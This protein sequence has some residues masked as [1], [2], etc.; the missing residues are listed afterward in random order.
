MMVVGLTGG[1][2]SGKSTV[3]KAFES[4]GVPVFYADAVAK[5]QYRD[6]HL[7]QLLEDH[8]KMSLTD[9]HGALDKKALAQRIFSD[10][11]AREW[12]NGLIH[13][14]VKHAFKAWQDSLNQPAYVLR[15]AA[16][17]IESGAYRDCRAILVVTAPENQRIQRVMKRDGLSEQEVLKR[18]QSQW[19]DEQRLRFATHTLSNPNGEDIAP[20]VLALHRQ[21]LELAQNP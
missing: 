7:I 15:E 5:D 17:L 10:S 20:K 1:I 11:K 18:L 6:P 13:P 16:I 2:G 9:T 4:L 19:N 21:F 12:V 14:R 8:L 3:A